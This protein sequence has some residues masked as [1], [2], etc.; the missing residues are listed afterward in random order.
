MA[1]AAGVALAVLPLLIS[2]IEDF[3]KIRQIFRRFRKYG[4]EL[5]DFQS[6]IKVQRTI[7]REEC[8][9][10]LA[11]VVGDE[12]ASEM[13]IDPSHNSWNDE[14][15]DT[16]M[17]TYLG[18]SGDA[19]M[20]NIRMLQ[21][22]LRSIEGDGDELGQNVLTSKKSQQQSQPPESKTW[23]RAMR[24]KLKFTFSESSLSQ[25][26][27]KIRDLNASFHR[28][29]DQLSRTSSRRIDSLAPT[30]IDQRRDIEKFQIIQKASTHL[31]GALASACTIHNEHVANFSLQ[32]IFAPN[33]ESQV[34]FNVSFSP[35]SSFNMQR[36]TLSGEPVWFTVESAVCTSLRKAA[37]RAEAAPTSTSSL[38][39]RQD[40]AGSSSVVNTQKRRKVVRFVSPDRPAVAV[41]ISTFPQ[42]SP[43]LRPN[44]CTKIKNC[45]RHL[46]PSE[47][48][49]GPLDEGADI[50]HLVYLASRPSEAEDEEIKSL[51]DLL[52]TISHPTGR[53]PL[54]KKFRFCRLLAT[55]VLQFH[56]T[57][58]LKNSW[59]SQDILV[60][61][62]LEGHDPNGL[63]QNE[64]ELESLYTN[65][66]IRCCESSD[67]CTS[68]Y[69]T[70]AFPP[71]QFLFGLGS[72]MLEIAFEKP[73]RNLRKSSDLD[74]CLDVRHTDFFTAQRLSATDL[75][76]TEMGLPFGN[77]VRKCIFCDFGKGQDLNKPELQASVYREVVCELS[78]LED[79][80]R[81]LQLGL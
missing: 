49:L 47:S 28:I 80:F 34:R 36:S 60:S 79:S 13:L 11:Q 64:L 15:L 8:R 76:S 81:K 68:A 24:E 44:F 78:R 1:E 51:D 50:Q 45:P 77:M 23:R 48:C 12:D 67:N 9:L 52:Q 65:V 59:R 71:N 56:A 53:L 63:R 57:P 4:D 58:W 20:E 30:S 31:Y 32:P 55:A 35:T 33:A 69:P 72:I 46:A 41:A 61:K 40:S 29:T 74:Q 27:E 54:Y 10:L 37:A 7:F 66:P 25:N 18:S 2:A 70:Y 17:S 42:L 22:R 26:I 73:L 75:A 43:T 14:K 39:K 3:G 16:D 19:C 6:E 38:Q 62:S 5:N 21:K